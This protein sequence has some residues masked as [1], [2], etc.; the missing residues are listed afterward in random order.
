MC[1]D[2]FA[3]LSDSTRREIVTLL[4]DAD[5]R[6]GDIAAQFDVT[7]PAVSQH[8]KVLRE[9]KLVKV[10]RRGRER[11][12]SLDLEGLAAMEAWVEQ[13]RTKWNSRLDRLAALV[14]EEDRDA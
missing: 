3:A 8:L 14:E 9:A 2:E 4:A 12:Y 5:R 11:V 7:P 1:M 13:T 6:A 10:E